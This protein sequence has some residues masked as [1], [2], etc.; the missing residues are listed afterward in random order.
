MSLT[1]T[2]QV[3]AGVS[4]DAVNDLM[5]AIF[6]ARP[7]YLNY[8]SPL[9]VPATTAFV[10]QVPAIAFPGV[11]GGIQYG[12]LFSIPRIDFHPDDSAGVSPLPPGIGQFTLHT[13]C[14]LFVGCTR[15]RG[16]NQPV[17]TTHV[18]PVSVSPIGTALDVFARG[19]PVASFFGPPGSGDVRLVLDDVEIVDIRP[20]SLESVI[21]CL[22]RMFLQAALA[23]LRLPFKALSMGAFDLILV[24]G[25]EVEQDQAQ[26][27]G[28]V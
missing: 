28:N 7:R 14:R 21:E 10:T 18:P 4:E 26:L 27:Y 2:E 13:T 19:H 1:E 23:N 5:T 9:F 3:F 24:R 25:P 17:A 6:S 12:V 20:D 8:G 15:L 22:I 11:P 16:D